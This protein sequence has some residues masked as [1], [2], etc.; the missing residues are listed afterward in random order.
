MIYFEKKKCKYITDKA[1][2][3]FHRQLSYVRKAELVCRYNA[4]KDHANC[5]DDNI[6]DH[7]DQREWSFYHRIIYCK[8]ITIQSTTIIRKKVLIQPHI[9][10]SSLCKLI[11][12]HWSY[13]MP[14]GYILSSV[15]V[16]L[17]IFS[18]LSI[19]QYMGLCVFYSSPI[20]LVHFVLLSPSNR[21][22]EIL[23]I[24]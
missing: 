14:V 19:I 4:F 16:R 9:R 21:K 7:E 18:Q 6:H 13:N 20:S 5:V 15:W 24:V 12:R 22:Y 1:W 10:N 23:S 3:R 8:Y 11:W 17:S 2:F